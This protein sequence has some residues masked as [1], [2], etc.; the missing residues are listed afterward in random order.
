MGRRVKAF[1]GEMST[2]WVEMGGGFG[3]FGLL[4]CPGA[5]AGV[6][7]GSRPGLDWCDDWAAGVEGQGFKVLDW[8]GSTL[9]LHTRFLAWSGQAGFVWA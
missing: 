1:G 3:G 6:W 8:A 7:V 9:G 2:C 4:G 5:S